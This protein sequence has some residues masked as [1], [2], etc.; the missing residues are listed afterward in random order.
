LRYNQS[1]YD[2]TNCVI[3]GCDIDTI[4]FGAGTNNAASAYIDANT[5][6]LGTDNTLAK[7]ASLGTVEAIGYSET[8]NNTPAE[9]FGD[10]RPQAGSVL[11]G[12]GVAVSGIT[13][14]IEGNLRPD[15]PTIGAYEYVEGA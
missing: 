8:L 10:F 12:A 1:G 2:I 7:F 9:D 15:P 3:F 6:V 11:I 13:D 4:D 5:L 14:D